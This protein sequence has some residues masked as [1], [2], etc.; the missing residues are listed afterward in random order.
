M[1]TLALQCDPDLSMMVKDKLHRDLL[2]R[3][4]NSSGDA[5]P[6]DTCCFVGLNKGFN[7]FKYRCI[8]L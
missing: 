8:V 2:H 7:E 4:P 1:Q 6:G 5:W 3:G